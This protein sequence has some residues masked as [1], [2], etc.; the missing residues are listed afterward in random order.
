LLPLLAPWNTVS[1]DPAPDLSARLPT[2]APNALM[3]AP[4]GSRMP[5][6]TPASHQPV[7][8]EIPDGEVGVL[9]PPVLEL[10]EPELPEPELPEVELPEPELPEV[11]P[12]ELELPEPELPEV[13]LPEVELPEVEPPELEPPEPELPD[14]ELL[15][16]L[17]AVLPPPDVVPASGCHRTGL[18]GAAS[19]I[20][21][22]GPMSATFIGRPSLRRLG[23]GWPGAP[24]SG[25][26]L[27][28][29]RRQACGKSLD[30]GSGG[31]S[32]RHCSRDV[33]IQ[34]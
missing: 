30:L 2:E 25:S 13:E 6:M 1:G 3:A 23:P 17:L 11:E 7:S 20:S 18:P 21:L 4:V 27:V 32:G 28:C 22:F 14:P 9:V 12:P 8:P 29:G 34:L 5:A 19:M 10:P 31:P 33:L 24:M 16:P 15:E 26:R